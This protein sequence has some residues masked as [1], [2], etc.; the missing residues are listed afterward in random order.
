MK[1]LSHVMFFCFLFGLG[2]YAQETFQPR[3]IETDYKGIV[4]NKELAFD[5]RIHTHGF[6]FSTK[7][8]KIKTYYKTKFVF[9]ELGELKH[10]KEVRK[11]FDARAIQTGNT[12]RSFIFGKKNNLLVFRTGIGTKKYLSEKARKKGLAVGYSY[13]FGAVLGMLKPYYLDLNFEPNSSNSTRSEQY[14]PEIESIFLN[15]SK[16]IGA[17]AFTKGFN[18]LS[19]IPGIHAKIGAHFDWGAFDKLVK[20]I[21]AGIMVDGFIKKAPIMVEQTGIENFPDYSVENKRIFLNLY[22]T[23]QLGKRR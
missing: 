11:S 18:E 10:H 2:A 7:I 19:F 17:S 8:G 9:F 5:L 15:E 22:L 12:T 16:I 3:N 21:E 23:L 4:Y 1:R 6:A 20:A 13:E 14:S